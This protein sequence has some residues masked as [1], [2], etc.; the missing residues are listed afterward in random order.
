MVKLGPDFEYDSTDEYS[1][2]GPTGAIWGFS[3]MHESGTGGSPKYGAVSQMPVVGTVP[4]PLVDLGQNWTVNDTAEIGYYKS[5]LANGVTIE[6][7]ATEHAGFYQYSFPAGN[8]SSV[9]VDVSHVLPSF[10]GLGWGQGYAGR[11]FSLDGNGSYSG[12]GI[13]NN[14]WNLAPNWTIHFCGH[15]DQVPS[16][17]KTF[18]GNGTTLDSYGSSSSTN[19]TFRQGGMVS[20]LSGPRMSLRGLGSASFLRRRLARTCSPRY[21][22]ELP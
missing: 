15:F 20:S 21:P 7:S 16:S 13:Y 3:L 22:H 12:Y 4:S 19:G 8:S 14:G 6:V 18:T 2:Y 9:V 1:G 17:S 5:S 10:R 11:N